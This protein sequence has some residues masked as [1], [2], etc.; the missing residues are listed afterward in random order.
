MALKTPRKK[1]LIPQRTPVPATLTTVVTELQ[2]LRRD[3]V[4]LCRVIVE[5]QKAQRHSVVA[6]LKK[7]EEPGSLSAN[8]DMPSWFDAVY[9]A[10]Q[11]AGG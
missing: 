3:M 4:V 11:E 2:G 7:A 6:A 9:E 8:V 5:G 10:N 1:K